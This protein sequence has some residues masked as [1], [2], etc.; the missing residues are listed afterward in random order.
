MGIEHHLAQDNN[1]NVSNA[2][3]ASNTDKS[4]DKK[5]CTA[6]IWLKN[7]S[8]KTAKSAI[9]ATLQAMD[10]VSEVTYVR[11]KPC[12]MMVDYCRH[13]IKAVKLIGAVNIHGGVARIVGC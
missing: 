2:I 11:D 10:G 6:I 3:T 9:A 1:V 5:R 7:H 13:Q 4:A 12:I 8:N